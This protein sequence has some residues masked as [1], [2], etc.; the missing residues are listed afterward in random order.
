MYAYIYINPCVNGPVQFRS[1]VF[2]SKLY[3]LKMETHQNTWDV[4]KAVLI[5]KFIVINTLD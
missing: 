4:A 1:V 5:G 2:K 3:P